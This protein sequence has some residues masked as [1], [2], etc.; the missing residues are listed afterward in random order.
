MEFFGLTLLGLAVGT[1]GTLLLSLVCLVAYG[2]IIRGIVPGAP[3]VSWESH[4]AGLISGVTLAWFTAKLK[5]TPLGP[6]A[7][8]TGLPASK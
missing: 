4:A 1:F 8:A 2:G 6:A 7:P 5:K 3:G